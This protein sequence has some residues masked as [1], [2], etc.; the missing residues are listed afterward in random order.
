M[1]DETKSVRVEP[2]ARTWAGLD[3]PRFTHDCDG[4]TYL[5]RMECRAFGHTQPYDLYA[6]LQG[7]VGSVVARYGSEGSQYTSMPLDVYV[8][9]WRGRGCFGEGRPLDAAFERLMATSDGHR[10][11]RRVAVGVLLFELG[12]LVGDVCVADL[13]DDEAV[14]R[15]VDEATNDHDRAVLGESTRARYGA[16]AALHELFLGRA[17]PEGLGLTKDTVDDIAWALR[18]LTT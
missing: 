5:G 8:R 14:R 16:R 17:L 9:I 4:C 1:S 18:T 6:C 7:R 15:V 11:L 3:P 13:A 10:A 2:G 12:E